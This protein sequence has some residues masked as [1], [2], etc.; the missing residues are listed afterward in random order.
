MK[1]IAC[2]LLIGFCGCAIVPAAGEDCP[3]T[4]ELTID[5]EG[6]WIEIPTAAD[7][8][9]KFELIPLSEK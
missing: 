8:A 9:F 4:T 2:V 7:R 3:N 1:R 5:E 6:R